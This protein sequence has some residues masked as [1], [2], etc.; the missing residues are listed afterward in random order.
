MFDKDKNDSS[1]IDHKDTGNLINQIKEACLCYVQGPVMYRGKKQTVESLIDTNTHL[2]AKC[3]ELVEWKE[4]SPRRRQIDT[5][6]DEF[7]QKGYTFN[8][9]VKDVKE[10]P[11]Q[12]AKKKPNK[13]AKTTTKDSLLL[14]PE[15]N[16]EAILPT[17]EVMKTDTNNTSLEKPVVLEKKYISGGTISYSRTRNT[18]AHTVKLPISPTKT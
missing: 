6:I 8:Y 7:K 1:C 16:D 15:E 11:D 10:V 12:K 14:A 9:F 5:E 2:L 13:I 3:Q 17:N 4:N 18:V